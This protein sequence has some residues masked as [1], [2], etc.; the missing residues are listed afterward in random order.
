M[1]QQSIKFQDNNHIHTHR[2]DWTDLEWLD[3]F[4]EFLQ[5]ENIPEEIKIGKTHAPKMSKKKAMAIIWYLQEHM[6]VFPDNIE[7]C[8]ICGDL[9]D[10]WSEG[11]Y[12][13][14][15]GKFYCGHCE[16][17]VPGHYDRGK[18]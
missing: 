15:K 13:E 1:K 10:T 16:Y 12:W 11:V 9:Y 7:K 3:E 5:G 4:Y 18:R 6:R 2:K 8:S 14:S 17:L